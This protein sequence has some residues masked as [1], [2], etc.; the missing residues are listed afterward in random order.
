MHRSFTLV[1][2]TPKILR[3][4]L[5]PHSFCAGITISPAAPAF[6]H[7]LHF[8]LGLCN[9]PFILPLN[10]KKL[11]LMMFI[12]QKQ[13]THSFSLPKD[14]PYI[15]GGYTH[16]QIYIFLVWRLIFLLKAKRKI[17][18]QFSMKE[19][20][21]GEYTVGII[22]LLQRLHCGR[23]IMLCFRAQSST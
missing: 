8:I 9:S 6:C 11:N 10:L 18:S 3:S 2:C 23:C 5:L 13:Q 15:I 4:A 14:F 19:G 16:G 22:D 12:L 21:R 20:W 17:N 7:S 1:L